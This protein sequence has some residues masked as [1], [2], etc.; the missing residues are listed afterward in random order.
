VTSGSF[1]IQ[2]RRLADQG[3][4]AA[5]ARKALLSM[6]AKKLK[7]NPSEPLSVSDGKITSKATRRS[8][9]YSALIGGRN[10]SLKVDK[11][12]AVKDP[13]HFKIVGRSIPRVDIPGKV[14]GTIHLHAGLFGFRACCMVAWF[15]PSGIGATL[16]GIDEDSV[17]DIP[18]LIRV[19][20]IGNFVGVIAET[21]WGR[22]PSLSATKSQLVAMGGPAGS[23]RTLGIRPPAPRS[24][25]R[26]SPADVGQVTATLNLRARPDYVRPMI[27]PFTPMDRL[28]LRVPSRSSRMEHSTCW[29]ASQGNSCLAEAVG[30]NVVDGP[31]SRSVASTSMDRAAMAVTVTT[32]R[33]AMPRFLSRAVGRPVRVQWMREDEH[34]WDSERSAPR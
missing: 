8:V 28:A 5:T 23:E 20:R 31:K 6:A 3:R 14:H 30:C 7:V 21:E 17:D 15:R 32:T 11:A 13:S 22:N 33:R 9:S 19:V 27:L 25:K 2:K 10:F 18:G 24:S 29:S 34:G 4:P 16:Q 26:M 1:S 12:A